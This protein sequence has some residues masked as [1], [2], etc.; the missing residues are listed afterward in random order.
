MD[1][2]QAAS[3]ATVLVAFIALEGNNYR[4]VKIHSQRLNLFIRIVYFHGT[5]NGRFYIRGSIIRL[6]ELGQTFVILLVICF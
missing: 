3:P 4:V 5:F 2:F 1:Y 6:D